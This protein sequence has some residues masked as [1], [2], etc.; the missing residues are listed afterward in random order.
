MKKNK[1][2][3][4]GE[5]QGKCEND[6]GST[7]NSPYWCQRCDDLRCNHITNQMEALSKKLGEK[8]TIEFKG[9]SKDEK[10]K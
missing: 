8:V 4:F 3:G 5:F 10:I 6:A 1:C 9:W 7:I 2:I